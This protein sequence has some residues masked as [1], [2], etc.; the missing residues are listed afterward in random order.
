MIAV[1]T[2]YLASV[3]L[4]VSLMVNNELR[5]RWLNMFGCLSFII[6]GLLIAA[7]PVVLTNAVL[8]LINVIYLFRTYNTK[9]NFD[10]LEFAPGDKI[11]SKFLQF[12]EKDINAY[13]PGFSAAF[14]E[15]DIRLVV[16]RDMVIANIFVA[17]RS[18]DATATVKVNYTVPKYRDFKVGTF[19]FRKNK[20]FLVEKGVKQIVYQQVNRT[21]HRKFLDRMGFVE[22]GG[23]V[24]K[25]L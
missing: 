8:L 24:I 15:N 12:Y 7:F 9:E 21:S 25:D 18:A 20:N 11:I 16:L 5:F 3:L 23:R 6:Y 1:L 2:G 13:F 4:A 17:E 10:V 22:R 19:L 14:N